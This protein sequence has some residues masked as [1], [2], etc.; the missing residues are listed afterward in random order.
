MSTK[1]TFKRVALVAV[2]ALGFGVLTSVSPANA[3]D[4]ASFTVNT[5]SVTVVTNGTTASEVTLGAIF[6]VS[7]RN[8][9]TT[10]TA[11]ALQST[12]SLTVTVVGVPTGTASTAKTVG[13]NAAELT[14]TK[15]APGQ[16]CTI[17][18][19]TGLVSRSRVIR[20]SCSCK[21]N[22]WLWVSGHCLQQQC[23]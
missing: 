7:L 15:L 1:T 17:C 3:A 5:D 22:K 20:F 12:E 18:G 19:R 6:K 23:W 8:D 16:W 2:A 13:A 4:T 10:Q 11:Q 14:I 9:G 21:W